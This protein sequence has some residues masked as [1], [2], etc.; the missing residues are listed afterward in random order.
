M[1]DSQGR[2]LGQQPLPYIGARPSHQQ[3]EPGGA[4]PPAAP[5]PTTE[6]V[7]KPNGG[8]IAAA[9]QYSDAGRLFAILEKKDEIFRA[10]MR[11]KDEMMIRKDEMHREDMRQ[12]D[13]LLER[14]RED[15]RQKDAQLERLLKERDEM[16]TEEITRLMQQ[17][18]GGTQQS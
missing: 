9:H 16:H 1:Q 3:L 12:K 6:W 4:P 17:L 8:V 15:M 18:G 5:G 11:K 2:H 14:Y 13:A 10:E 7:S